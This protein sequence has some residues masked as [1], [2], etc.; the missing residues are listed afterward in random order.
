MHRENLY[1][2][3]DR[4]IVGDTFTSRAPMDN[5]EILCDDLGARFA[6]TP[7]ERQAAEFIAATF[8]KYG[9]ENARLE[10]YPYAGWS[11]GEARLEAKLAAA[12]N[13]PG[14]GDVDALSF[15]LHTIEKFSR[16]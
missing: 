12:A 7:Q 13:M 11:R 10:A 6:G 15:H 2:H 16:V 3:I 9:L 8:K 4:Q 14:E 5:L 1:L